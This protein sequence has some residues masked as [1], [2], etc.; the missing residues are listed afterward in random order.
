MEQ[1]KSYTV[2]TPQQLKSIYTGCDKATVENNFEIC[3]NMSKI[4]RGS[5]L[6]SGIC[7]VAATHPV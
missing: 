1:K 7:R 2:S 4:E 6:L 5:S 3:V